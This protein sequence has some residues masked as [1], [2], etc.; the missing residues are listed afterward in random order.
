MQNQIVNSFTN[1]LHEFQPDELA[2]LSLT[3]KIELPFRDR[4][5][6]SMYKEFKNTNTVVSREWKRTDLALLENGSPSAL[7]E[8]KAMYSFDAALKSYDIS[9]FT[10]AMSRDEEKAKQL[11]EENTEI[12]TVLL[13]T[14]P[15]KNIDSSL[16]GIVKYDTGINK[17][18]KRFKSSSAVKDEA[19]KA[20]NS[21]MKKRNIIMQ[22]E[23]IAG[24]AFGIDTLI[25]YWIV[26]V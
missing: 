19:I 11:A 2:Y 1:I 25:L 15:E 9:G 22:G 3:T 17:A 6:Y 4:W 12:F 8:L 14:H 5:A 24:R 18:I 7:I 26:K 20:V 16:S 10:D 23:L 21:N 13:A